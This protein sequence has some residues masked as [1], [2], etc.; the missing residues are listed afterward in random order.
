MEEGTAGISCMWW[1]ETLAVA[2][3]LLYVFFAYKKRNTCWIFALISS[4]LYVYLCIQSNLYLES[5]LQLFYVVMAIVGWIM[6]EKSNATENDIS[7]WPL[8]RHIAAIVLGGLTTVLFGFLFAYFTQQASP[9]LDAFTTVFS[10]MATYLVAKKILSNWLYWVVIDA[11]SILLYFQRGLYQSAALFLIFT[12]IALLGF[13][14]WRKKYL[15]QN[16]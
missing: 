15:E 5:F 7:E 9:Y 13:Y 11:F 6:W 14:H 3:S 8:K 4:S 1:I 16:A 2:S 12:I 10:L